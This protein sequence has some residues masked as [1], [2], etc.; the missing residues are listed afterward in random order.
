MHLRPQDLLARLP[1]PATAM[2]PDGV[3]DI[4]AFA[5]S[6]LSL[7]LFAPRGVDYQ[8][9]HAQDELYIVIAGSAML[10]IDGVEHAC[11]TGDALFV[12]ARVPH[13]FMNISDD[14]VAWV[15]FWGDEKP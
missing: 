14:F 11:A 2:W 15:I 1:L 12:P 6:G 9:P 7:E 10:E 5:R 13:R 8:T 4:E 3:Y